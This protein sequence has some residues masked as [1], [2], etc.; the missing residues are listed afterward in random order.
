M[1]T[2]EDIID[3]D[4]GAAGPLWGYD[5]RAHFVADVAALAVAFGS[6]AGLLWLTLS[7]GSASF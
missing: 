3:Y 5:W 6:A 1:A 7:G 4:D 2:P